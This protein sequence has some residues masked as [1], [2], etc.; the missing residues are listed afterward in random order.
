MGLDIEVDPEAFLAIYDGPTATGV[1]AYGAQDVAHR[2]DLGDDGV[3]GVADLEADVVHTVA[4]LVEELA[5]CGGIVIGLVQ[6]DDE[7]ALLAVDDRQLEAVGGDLATV[8]LVGVHRRLG[9][10]DLGSPRAEQLAPGVDRRLDVL[11]HYRDLDETGERDGVL[12]ETSS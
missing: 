5:E 1:H 10:A 4:V 11:H 8:S 9:D 6:L 2:F 7:A 3:T 12:H